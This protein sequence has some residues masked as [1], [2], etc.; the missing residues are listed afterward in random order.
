M[1]ICGCI[2]YTC[3]YIYIYCSLWPQPRSRWCIL[4][5]NYYIFVL[6][7]L[8]ASCFVRRRMWIP[9]PLRKFS[10]GSKVDKNHVQSS[11]KKG[12]DKK[13]KVNLNIYLYLS[14]I[15]IILLTAKFETCGE[16]LSRC[17]YWTYN[18]TCIA[19]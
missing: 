18:T 6:Y 7:S 5:C 9:Q 19:E 4:K 11:A 13:Y 3:I 1:T 10:N 15:A 2:L 16:C 8:R 14:A 12:S 17:P